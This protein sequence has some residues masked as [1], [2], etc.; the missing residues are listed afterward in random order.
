MK[1]MRKALVLLRDLSRD[2]RGQ[3]VVEYIL[4][5]SI[6]VMS[7]GALGYGLRKTLFSLWTVFARE[8][9]AACPGCPSD[10]KALK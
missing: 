3:A 6:T 7:V 9:S 5:V 10:L 2:D 1:I 4:M 8:I